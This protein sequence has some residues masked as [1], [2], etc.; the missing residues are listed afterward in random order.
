MLDA[1]DRDGSLGLSELAQ[2]A[3]LV[4]EVLLDLSPLPLDVVDAAAHEEGLLGD[5]VVHAVADLRERLD[6]V[7]RR[8]RTIPRCR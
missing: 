8:D 2:I 4:S 5:V 7:G 6:G 1:P 3:R